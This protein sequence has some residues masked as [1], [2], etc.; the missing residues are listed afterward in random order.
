MDN[1]RPIFFLVLLA[2]SIL[3]LV[4]FLET[5]RVPTSPV[6]SNLTA[7]GILRGLITLGLYV[8]FVAMV[9]GS[10]F[11]VRWED[12]QAQPEEDADSGTADRRAVG[13]VVTPY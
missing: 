3:F 5:T 7:D 6:R 4:C 11:F 13:I 2:G 9:F 8:L 12:R 1:R 10:Y